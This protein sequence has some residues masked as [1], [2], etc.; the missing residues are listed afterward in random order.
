MTIPLQNIALGSFLLGSVALGSVALGSAILGNVTAPNLPFISQW[1]TS[2][3]SAG[4]SASNQ[5][6][7]PLE[8]TGT[9]SFT[10]DW[11]DGNQDSITV[12]NQ[13]ETTHT[14]AVP[15]IYTI[16]IT[17][18][19][20]GFRFNNTLDRLK[21]LD[22]SRWGELKIG[23]NGSYFFGCA[24][25][26]ITASDS[27]DL[28]STT[29]LSKAFQGANSFTGTKTNM[30]LWIVSTVTNMEETFRLA[31]VFN[32]NIAPWDVSS[33]TTL[34]RTFREALAFN[35]PIGSWIVSA[36]TRMEETFRLASVFNG[37]IAPWDVS[38]VNNM[39]GTFRGAIA[40]NQPI[41]S[42]IVSAVTR[43]DLMFQGAS[44]FNQ[45]IG[46][47]IVSAVTRMDRMFNLAI[48]FNQPIGSW[49]VSAVTRMD[50]MFNGASSF[51]QPIGSWI[52]SA[53]T[54]MDRMFEGA[55][56]FNQDIG[57][58]IV[59]AVTTMANMFLG[60]TLSTI[61]YDSILIGWDGL[62]S[63]QNNV[64]FSGGNSQYS[65]GAATTARANIIAT[66]SWTITDG[67]QVP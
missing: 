60:V 64:Q 26:D 50:R 19:I 66:F 17:G 20:D 3:T 27:P 37:N 47:W 51:N 57:S 59:S 23:N 29:N 36:V 13:A 35:Q 55:I 48:A 28:S 16:T 38:A 21:I 56:A 25:W 39:S 41:G 1:N 61:N 49:I 18:I 4:S 6:A 10:V 54:R 9:Y 15:G 58:W 53:V 67:G 65:V 7:L 24:N 43:M 63:L 22:I 12:W 14:Y 32:G 52:V 34:F 5:V 62:S 33:V 44:S 11:G 2:N 42:W 46:S 45:P 40:F 8:S 30:G 31:S